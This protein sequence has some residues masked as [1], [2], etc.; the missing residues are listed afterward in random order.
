MPRQTEIS[1][2]WEK[3]PR[4]LATIGTV[5]IAAIVAVATLYTLIRLMAYLEWWHEAGL[6]AFIPMLA[7]AIP[8]SIATAS[9]AVWLIN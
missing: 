7:V 3:D 4:M 5:T 8:S 2:L 6:A 9:I 1:S